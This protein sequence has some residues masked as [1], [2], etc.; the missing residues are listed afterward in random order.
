METYLCDLV[1]LFFRDSVDHAK[2]L[3]YAAAKLLTADVNEGCEVSKTDALTAVLTGSNLRDDLRCDVT[4]GGKAVGLFDHGAADNGAVLEHILEIDKVAVV[5]MLCEIVCVM[6]MD[7]ALVVSSYNV[8]RKKESSCDILA[9]LACHVVALNAVDSGVFIGVFL[10]DF[11][12]VA[13]DEGKDLFVCGV[14]FANERTVVTIGDVV[15]CYIERA[16][17]HEL[18]FYHILNLFHAERTVDI[19]RGAFHIFRNAFDLNGG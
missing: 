17:I 2:L 6:E 15:S 4:S 10:L 11:F 12:V 18:I 13:F 16:K 14:G 5:H 19:K 9:D 3:A 7:D 8:C 1:D